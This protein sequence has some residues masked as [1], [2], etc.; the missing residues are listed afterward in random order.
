MPGVPA[1]PTP[2]LIDGVRRVLG[3]GGALASVL[4]GFEPR[5]SQQ[6]MAEAVARV[7][8]DSGV[9]LAEAGTGTGKT[10]AYLVPA[11]LSGRKVLVSTGT[12]NLQQQ[13]IDKD[14]PLLQ[15]A[16]GPF[17]A[18]CMKGRANYLCLHRFEQALHDDRPRDDD[19]RVA[20]TLIEHWAPRTQTGDRAELADLPE[21]LPFWHGIA[22]TTE[23]CLGNECPRYTD[24]FVTRMRQE[25]A[26]ADVVIVNHHLLCADAAVRRHSFGEVIPECQVGIVDEAHQLED[27][28][29]QYFGVTVSN[30]R[31]E[32]LFT[33][34]AAIRTSPLFVPQQDAQAVAR[35]IEGLA[36]SSRGF[37][38]DL[39]T[40][41]PGVRQSADPGATLFDER[42]RVTGETLAEAAG[43]SGLQ[44][45]DALTALEEALALLKDAPEDLRAIG[46]RA[47]EIR[48]DMKFLLRARE[49][50]YVYFLEIR[51]RHVALR[52]API[53]VSHIIRDVLIDRLP[54]LVLTSATLSIGGSF[55]YVRA[56]LGIGEA[57]E[58]RVTSEFDYRTQ[59]LVYLPRKM[60]DPRTREYAAAFAEEAARLL[61]ASEGRAFL[62]FT[63][64]A[65]LRDAH[66]RLS[67]RLPYP[68]FVQGT[69]PRGVLIEQFRRTPNA[70]LFGTSSFWQGVDV[71]GDALSCV[72]IDRIP[73]ASPGDPVVAARIEALQRR[74]IDAFAGFQVPLAI[75]TLLQGVGRLIRHRQDRGVI[76]LLDPRLQSMGYGRRFLNAL[77]PAPVT[78]R[79]EDVERFFAEV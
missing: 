52:A 60:P 77:P 63:S 26:D 55:G 20:M 17:R 8:T 14:V 74:G 24:C 3:T 46:R 79:P 12:R 23:N 59:A 41:R 13:L 7:V 66:A 5:A 38:L 22:A 19:T 4:D 25:A 37:F 73:F 29:T 27:V 78:R 76:A 31:V 58:V 68:M 16:L 70:V 21:D 71:M 15:R 2:G 30:Y 18:A 69:V 65:A 9:L 49:E 53:D 62:L 6:Q 45:I 42:L 54:A 33:D 64:Y 10:L 44:L 57:L 47:G 35:A 61:T 40:R 51:G 72:I 43:E 1:V 36:S 56:R 67:T 50:E 28:A 11:I 75:L 39:Q 48:D 34:A 32:Q